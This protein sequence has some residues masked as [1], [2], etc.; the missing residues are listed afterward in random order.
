MQCNCWEMPDG[1]TKDSRKIADGVNALGRGGG[2]GCFPG[3]WKLK[4]NLHVYAFYLV[5]SNTALAFAITQK[6]KWITTG[7]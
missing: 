6:Q 7:E 5:N 3:T 2:C 4:N 1:Q